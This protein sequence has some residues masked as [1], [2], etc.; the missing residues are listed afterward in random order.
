[1]ESKFSFTNTKI[2]GHLGEE[3]NLNKLH[4]R[5]G[6][7]SH[8]GDLTVRMGGQ[9]ATIPAKPSRGSDKGKKETTYAVQQ[10]LVTVL[11]KLGASEIQ[12]FNYGRIEDDSCLTTKTSGTCLICRK[13]KVTKNLL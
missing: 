11:F 4:T 9:G 8:F 5:V 1:M 13:H 10:V 7:K 12:W 3:S 2:T 6:S